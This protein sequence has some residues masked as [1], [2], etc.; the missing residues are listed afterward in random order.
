SK[1]EYEFR[2]TGTY[3]GVAYD[4]KAHSEAELGEK[5]GRRKSEI[6]QGKQKISKQMLVRDW[7]SQWREVYKEPVVEDSTMQVIDSF[8]N[9]INAHIGTLR[10]C[11][12]EPLHCQRILNDLKGKSYSLMTKT[13]YYMKDLFKKAIKSN[14]MYTNPADDLAMPKCVKGTH[15]PLSVHERKILLEVCE[16][17]EYGLWV[18]IMLYCGLRP[19]ET[20]R[21][22][23][24]HINLDEAKVFVDGTKSDAAV[25]YVPLPKK[26][27]E[28]LPKGIEKSFGYLFTNNDGKPIT[29][30]NR[31]HMWISVKKDMH[32]L[33]GGK[34]DYGALKR[35]VE[36]HRVADDLV[37]Y[38][39]RHTYCTDLQSAGVPINVAKELMGHSSIE[40]T[41]NI[42]THS[43]LDAFESARSMIDAYAK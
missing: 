42:Y 16:H 29:K 32:I 10:L 38:C 15:R 27:A 13:Q 6:D 30:S 34:T 14:L 2:E 3:D 40:M 17:H 5:V 20:A 26:L 41:A 8:I 4:I 37:P 19:G 23:G 9:R 18:L 24:V 39:L 36:P 35:I 33:M 11:E 28:K 43:S 22:K 31:K 7:T 1:T 21:V 12:V 25:R